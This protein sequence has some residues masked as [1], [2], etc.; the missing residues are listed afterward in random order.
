MSINVENLAPCKK[1]LRIEVDAADV[2]ATFN[3]VTGQFRK[4]AQL[5]GFRQGKAPRAVVEKNFGAKIQEEVKKKLL[6]DAYQSAMEKENLKAADYPEIEELQFERGQ[7]FKFAATV[8]TEPDFD[9]P[10][11]KG[12]KVKRETKV[13]GDEDV[14]AA[15]EK[16]R[17]QRVDYKDVD[18]ELQR[19]DIAVVDYTGTSE[20]KPLTDIAPTARGLTENKNFWVRAESEEFIPGFADQ[21]IGL[22]AGD[23]KTVEVNFPAEFVNA[24]LAGRK[25]SYEVKLNQV[26]ERILPELDDE[27]ASSFGGESLEKMREGIKGDLE[28]EQKYQENRDIRDQL[29]KHL[30]TE[31]K[32]DLPESVVANETRNTVYDIVA[33]N[34]RRGLGKDV[35][36]Q[37]KDEIFSAAN[38]NAKEKVRAMY[39]LSRIAEKES[40]KAEQQE[41]A[42]RVQVMAQQYQMPMDK[43]VKQLQEKNGFAEIQEQ[44]VVGKVLDFLQ[45]NASVEEVPAQA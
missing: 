8:E 28:N 5:P 9:L 3:D 40:I 6:Q 35:I 7:A 18:R 44:V 25:G 30:M 42:A 27:F 34:Q 23:E 22:K 2:D 12:I 39:L 4:H 24:E 1:L 33:E 17:E 26:K 37:Q 29:V 19:G 13:V 11:Y 14:D 16:L 41:I 15:L 38:A 36:E 32:F 45:L 21:L 43:L 20:G 31:T 10:D